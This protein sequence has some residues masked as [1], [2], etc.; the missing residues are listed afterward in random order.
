M[1]LHKDKGAAFQVSKVQKEADQILRVQQIEHQ[2]QQEELKSDGEARVRVEMNARAFRI[3]SDVVWRW[4]R[5]RLSQSVYNWRRR[6]V[7][8]KC[9][10]VN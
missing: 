9:D 6:Q 1:A 7:I 10:A 3:M 8:P 5:S 4:K 2:R